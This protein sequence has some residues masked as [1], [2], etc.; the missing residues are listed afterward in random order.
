MKLNLSNNQISELEVLEKVNFKNLKDLDITD[1]N[2]ININKYSTLVNNLNK[3]Y[4]L[5]I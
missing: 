5:T 2:L 4:Y 1:N 3:K